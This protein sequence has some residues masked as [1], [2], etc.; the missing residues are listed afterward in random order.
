MIKSGFKCDF[1]LGRILG[2]TTL[3][4]ITYVFLKSRGVPLHPRAHKAATAMFFMG[5]MQVGLGITTLLTYVPVSIAAMH[6]SGAILTLSTALW[7]SHE[8]KLMKV[9]KHIPK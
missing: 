3:A 8:L 9:L 2:T 6:Q 5:W 4:F 7:L 1:F